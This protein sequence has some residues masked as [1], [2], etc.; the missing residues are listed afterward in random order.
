[1][2][3]HGKD[4]F[5]AVGESY[6]ETGFSVCLTARYLVIVNAVY[7]H[8]A[9]WRRLK[10]NDDRARFNG[11]SAV[12]NLEIAQRLIFFRYGVVND[13]EL[14]VFRN[15]ATGGEFQTALNLYR[16]AVA[17]FYERADSG[18]RFRLGIERYIERIR[19]RLSVIDE[20]CGNPRIVYRQFGERNA[21]KIYAVEKSGLKAAGYERRADF[22]IVHILKHDKIKFSPRFRLACVII[23]FR[24]YLFVESDFETYIIR[25][26][27]QFLGNKTYDFNGLVFFYEFVV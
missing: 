16:Y 9:F 18:I 26:I 10:R 5:P 1:M 17:V 2:I 3:V 7:V 25:G 21:V 24:R 22:L 15:L 4:E 8:V 6:R 11:V 14:A 19:V 12:I 23:A 20:H 13:F 27:R